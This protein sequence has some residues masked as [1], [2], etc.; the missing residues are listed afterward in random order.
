MLSAFP[1][2]RLP[3]LSGCL[4]SPYLTNP[5]FT[6]PRSSPLLAR[7]PFPLDTCFALSQAHCLLLKL[8]NNTR[9]RP[10]CKNDQANVEQKNRAVVRQVIGYQRLQGEQAYQP[11]AH[12]YLALRL[13]VNVFQPSMRVASH[14]Y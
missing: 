13:Y 1:S 8:E 10:H 3:F 4:L 6:W 11:L 7:L 12:V 9:G 14:L 2:G 5:S